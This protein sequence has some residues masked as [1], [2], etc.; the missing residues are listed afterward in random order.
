MPRLM[1]LKLSEYLVNISNDMWVIMV[2][3][4]PLELYYTHSNLYPLYWLMLY[5]SSISYM[6]KDGT[7][8]LSNKSIHFL[9]SS[10][11]VRVIEID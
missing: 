10:F 6:L 2:I 11:R 8:I 7:S 4:N 5:V 3:N 1:I 9:G